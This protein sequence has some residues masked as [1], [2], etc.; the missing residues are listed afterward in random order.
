MQTH[1]FRVAEIF[2]PTIQGEG[3]NIG[4]PCV[5]VRFGGCDYRCSWCDTPHAV[6]PHLVAQLPKM[7]E[8]GILEELNGLEGSPNWVVLSGGNPGLLNLQ[9]LI[10]LLHRRAHLVMVETQGSTYRDW[11]AAV[12]DLCF[13]PKP[14][15]SGNTTTPHDLGEVIDRY[16]FWNPSTYRRAYLKVVVFD[17]SDYEYA[18]EIHQAFPQFEFFV[19]VGNEDPSLPTV[20]KPKASE[21]HLPITQ[22]IV[23]NKMAWLMDKVRLDSRMFEARVL[24]QMHVLAWGNVRGR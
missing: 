18:V 7:N 13:S 16:I 15:S 22:D 11:Y 20:G 2:G 5:F 6:L 4:S 12:D 3:R 23:L 19:S 14:P 21:T 8:W 10:E 9:Y 17:D 1:E 24:P